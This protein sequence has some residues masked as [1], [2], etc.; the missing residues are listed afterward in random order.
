MTTQLNGKTAVTP[1]L[2]NRQ[3]QA[4]V[5]DLLARM[6]GYTPGWTPVE[7]GPSWAIIQ[8]YAR[9]L[10]ALAER[11]GLAPDKNKLAFLD[12]LG[13]NL[14]PAQA[15]RAPVVFTPITH[16]GN[17]RV[18]ART[19]VGA[20]NPAGG[21]TLIFETE[22]SIA[23]AAANLVEVVSLWPG[24][25]GY[26]DHA[27]AVMGGQPFTLFSGLKPTPHEFY[28]AHDT[29]F[30]LSGKAIVELQC[31]LALPGNKPVDVAWAYWDGKVWREF[32][33]F[34]PAA[35]AR[36]DDSVDGTD[37]LTKSGVI[38]LAAD[39][40]TTE[41]TT[42]QGRTSSWLRGRLTQPLPPEPGLVLAQLDRL[43]VRTVINRTLPG[44]MPLPETAGF[45]P[46]KAFANTLQL[47]VSKAIYPLGQQ[48]QPGSAFYLNSAEALGK[49]GAEVT[50]HLTYVAPEPDTS[51]P[52]PTPLTTPVVS[53]EYWNGR[54]WATLAITAEANVD[55]F[56][57]DGRL[58]FTVPPDI[59]P[60]AVNNETGLWIRARLKSGGYGVRRTLTFEGNS[61]TVTEIQPPVLGA[62]QIGYLYRSPQAQPA[63]CLAYND[64]QWGD[65]S[66][67][68]RW[69]GAPF[70]PFSLVADRAPT[71]YLGFD[72]PLPADQISLYLDIAEVTGQSSGPLLTWEYHDGSSWRSLAVT[73]ETNNLALPGMVTAV[74]PGARP[75]PNGEAV[76]AS[77]D[78]V[79]L[80]NARQAARFRPG[81]LIAIGD[82]D[83]PELMTVQSVSN[84][85]LTLTATLS[86]TYQRA[87]VSLAALPRFGKPRAWLRAR[88]QTDGNPLL[89]QVNGIHSNAV[90][91]TQIQT[92]E[93]EALGSSNGQANQ[94]FFSRRSPV[95]AGEWLEVKELDGA[96]AAVEL[97]ILQQELA[98]QGLGDEV[99]TTVTDPRSGRISEVWVRWQERPH[100][101]FSRPDA[102]HY[103]LERSRG[104]IIFGDDQN[105]RIPSAGADNIRLRR[106]RSGGGAAGNV[107]ANSITQLLSGVPAAGAANPVAAEGGADTEPVDNVLFRGPQV[108]RH[109]YQAISL[110]DYEALAR[111]ASPAVAVARALPVTHSSGRQAPGWVKVIIMPHSQEARPQPSFGL[112]RQVGAFLAARVPAAVAGQLTVT[113]P[114]YLPVGVQTAVTPLRADEAGIVRE[115]VILALERFLHPL[116]GGPEGSGWAFGRDVYLSDVAAALEAIPGVDYVSAINLLLRGSPSGERL[117]VPPDRIVV[118]GMLQIMLA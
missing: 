55:I 39:C 30:A 49:P 86:Q 7:N 105:G 33:S 27:T 9:Y 82:E 72:R 70:E 1:T 73:D 74:Y 62:M 50:L 109:R 83:P 12:L 96:R 19:Q 32:K 47:D 88:Q 29:H 14:L 107:A 26:A 66:E 13:V 22:T 25:D 71:L 90:W 42:I 68:A 91:A 18:P 106:Y 35:Q 95:L 99:I 15:A 97:A 63:H 8:I 40:S 17:G 102:R 48:P 77:G 56:Q 53:W 5:A 110:S 111:E 46:D 85:T 2:D 43:T 93:N 21:E 54:S 118:A 98:E 100:F 104:R 31:E 52:S 34:K 16:V 64:F 37:G 116:T 103:V 101:F 92:I 80:A 44:I 94:V 20:A 4:L 3:I 69:R 60:T 84:S 117:E 87:S 45:P 112:R 41:P 113:G 10:R 6:P 115:A 38:R 58:T 79:Q 24:K 114:T 51:T 65:Y 75:L 57:A 78:Q 28:L 61:I 23:L 36:E 59:S 67:N 81:D 76:T 89:A 11:V 108:V